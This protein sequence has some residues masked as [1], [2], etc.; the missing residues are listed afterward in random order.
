MSVASSVCPRRKWKMSIFADPT[1]FFSVA[2]DCGLSLARS[3]RI[4]LSVVFLLFAQANRNLTVLLR[5]NESCVH[6]KYLCSGKVSTFRVSRVGFNHA[7]FPSF[8][9]AQHFAV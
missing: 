1:D 2:L 5:L 3:C 8:P 6:P 7:L 4:D 9:L